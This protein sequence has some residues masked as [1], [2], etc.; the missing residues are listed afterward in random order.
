ME[1]FQGTGKPEGAARSRGS[2]TGGGA[3]PLLDAT[4]RFFEE[5]MNKE[6]R[7]KLPQTQQPPR[8]VAGGNPGEDEGTKKEHNA[9][10][11]FG[12]TYIYDAMK[13]KTQL[14]SLLVRSRAM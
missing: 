5:F 3:T 12:P 10:D 8:Q 4:V 9:V 11:S 14:K 1:Y 7:K 13:E 2:E 6:T